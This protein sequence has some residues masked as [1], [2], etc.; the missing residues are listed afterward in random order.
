MFPFMKNKT[1]KERKLTEMIEIFEGMGDHKNTF[2]KKSSSEN[3]H[4]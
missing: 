4:V 2:P 1:Q 3:N